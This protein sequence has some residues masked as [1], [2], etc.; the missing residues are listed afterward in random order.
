MR[1][2][3]IGLVVVSCFCSLGASSL[4]AQSVGNIVGLVVDASGG[5]ISP[6]TVNITNS[7]IDVE[8][9]VQTNES[10]TCVR[11]W[12]LNRRNLD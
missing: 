6:T 8:R 5:A 9:A 7:E 3:K 1:F 12:E 10:G 11:N 4:F 2:A